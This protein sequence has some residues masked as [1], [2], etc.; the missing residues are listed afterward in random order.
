MRRLLLAV[1]VV[2]PI[3]ALASSRAKTPDPEPVAAPQKAVPARAVAPHLTQDQLDGIRQRMAA[4][5]AVWDATEGA[6]RAP[7]PAEAAA[8]ADTSS[9]TPTVVALPGGGH[10][11][12]P[13]GSDLSFA[14]ATTGANSTVAI[15]H[16]SSKAAGSTKGGRDVR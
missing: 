8:L 10:A 3:L 14:I 13:G 5:I 4:Q 16:S 2:V 9:G 6:M 1:C 11:L 12:R 15:T 7:T